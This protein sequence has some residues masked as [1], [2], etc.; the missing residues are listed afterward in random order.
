VSAE[1][2]DTGNPF[3]IRASSARLDASMNVL[4]ADETFAVVDRFGDIAP[5]GTG[6]LGLYRSGTRYLSSMAMG[7]DGGRPFLLSSGV[8]RDNSAFVADLTNPDLFDGDRIAVPRGSVHLRKQLRVT[9][10]GLHL[11]LRLRS[12]APSAVTVHLAFVFDADF[13]DIFEVRGMTRSARGRRHPIAY[14]KGGMRFVYTGLDHVVR[15]ATVHARPPAAH[16]AA[17]RLE[18]PVHLEAGKDWV[19][20]LSVACRSSERPRL[21]KRPGALPIHAGNLFAL[22]A[23]NEELDLWLHRSAVDL[24][25]MTTRTRWGPYPYA[26]APW[27]SAPFGRDGIIT[28][29][30]V[31][32]LDPEPARGVLR[33]LAATQATTE[34][35]E[36]DAEPGKILHEWRD[37]E[38]ANLGEVPFGRYYG[39]VDATP[40][41]VVLAGAYFDRTGDRA[42]LE[43][44]WPNIER[45][46]AW[47]D[48]YGDR[49][50]DGFIEYASHATRG[51]VHQGWKDSSDA[52]FHEDGSPAVPPIALCEVQGYAFAARRAAAEV[53]RAL[54]NP[55]LAARLTEQADALRERFDAAFWDPTRSFYCFALDGDKKPCR[56]LTSNAGHTLWSGIAKR[57]RARI[58]A[59]A[60]LGA[61]A[62]SGW[63]VRTVAA[64]QKGFNPMSYHDGSVW[65]HDNALIAA[66]LARFGH[67]GH[68]VRVLTGMFDLSRFVAIRRLPELVCGFERVP[69]QAPTL[70]PLACAPQAWSS[71]A[72]FLLIQSCLGIR[73]CTPERRIEFSKPRLP[74]FLEAV[75]IDGLRVGSGKVDLLVTRR[76]GTVEVHVERAEGD[77]AVEVSR[78]GIA[79][80][81]AS[82]G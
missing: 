78:A 20:Q 55:D 58:M 19:L 52:V 75:R 1:L 66:G 25:M 60:L 42:L 27:F 18:F 29:L 7:L 15:E 73:V 4:K 8:R 31:L 57:A 12:Y 6:D 62:F 30:E 63:G 23:S 65:P 43:E 51:L 46:L 54:G 37:S 44:L 71:G 64:G 11:R 49:D 10:A 2:E 56:V 3:A 40:L 82:R 79:E 17:Q 50:G 36:R 32:W 16:V 74:R 21:L 68:A 28:A 67:T 81:A 59:D 70:Y 22:R 26:G 41:F 47:M 80:A 38:M 24:R 48:T 76:T 35:P 14:E 45:A 69:G 33:F 77:V 53:A 5:G 61:D 9:P 13:A 39:S 34:D 72:A